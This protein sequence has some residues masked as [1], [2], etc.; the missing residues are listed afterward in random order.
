MG[1]FGPASSQSF[2]F[3]GIP[4]WR[5]YDAFAWGPVI[6][7]AGGMSMDVGVGSLLLLVAMLLV[8]GR[9]GAARCRV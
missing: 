8:G 3:R 2:F 6:M 9:R 4:P 7:G 5:F 1:Y